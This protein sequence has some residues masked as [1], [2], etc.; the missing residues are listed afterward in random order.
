MN[1]REPE[2]ELEFGRHGHGKYF[3]VHLP[4]VS[5]E[6]W[7]ADEAPTEDVAEAMDRFI[8]RARSAL[9]ALSEKVKWHD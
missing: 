6:W 1:S 3:R 7:I 8:R 9:E 5:E 4:T 2:F